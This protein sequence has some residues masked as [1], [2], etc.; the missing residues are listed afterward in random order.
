M[1]RLRRA[2][3]RLAAAAVLAGLAACGGGSGA[4]ED[5]LLTALAGRLGA[6]TGQGAEPV[7]DAR[8]V[9]TPALVAGSPTP[10]ILLVVE[11]TDSGSTLVPLAANRGTVQWR[12]AAGGGLLRRDGI[13]VGTR[14][15]GF[16]LH[17]ADVAPLAA[18]L[19]AGGGEGVE[20]VNRFIDGENQIVAMQYLCS[21]RPVR[22][23]ALNLYGR[24]V[25]TVVYEE[26]C[27]DDGPAFV[28]QY[29]V[30]GSGTVLRSREFV[31]PVSGVVDI[32]VLRQ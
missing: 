29:W 19:R 27:I 1:S 22:G 32:T 13:L 10:L 6:V 28:N 4:D 21:V 18:A 12:D 3:Q 16:D 5:V 9:L 15:F 31:H 30:D 26:A 17:T 14:G 25:Q 24:V 20:R 7:P 23:E 2:A 11:E 8:A